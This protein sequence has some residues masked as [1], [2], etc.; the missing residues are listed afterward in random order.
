METFIRDLRFGA[1]M[2]VRNPRF[3]SLAV[4][5]LALG[6]GANTLVFSTVDAW[7]VRPLPFREPNRLA[8]VWESEAKSPNTPSIFAPWRHYQEW[9]RQAESFEGLAG[10][11]WRGY[12]LTGDGET[13][14]LLG[15]LVTEDYF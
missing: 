6:I 1:R 3:S 15:Q 9:K 5:M 8:A 14:S 7:L 4:L 10:F 2:L 12:T 13:E 11:F